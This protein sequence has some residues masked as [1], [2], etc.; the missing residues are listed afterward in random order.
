MTK[1]TQDMVKK[2]ES[3]V[4]RRE[5]QSNRRYFVPAADILETQDAVV[6]T[7]DMP[8]VSKENVDL[9]ADKGT[10]TI[11]GTADPEES[12]TAVYRE[13]HIGDYRRQ[14]SLPEDMDTDRISAVM[15]NGVLT[16]TLRKP[17]EVKPRKIQIAA[18]Q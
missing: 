17:E 12:G 8:G 11:T 5:G 9:T 10:L 2:E 4:T 6:L 1:E 3:A 13:T 16:V 7:L 18:G 14:F 15:K